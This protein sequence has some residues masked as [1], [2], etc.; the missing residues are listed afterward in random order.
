MAFF[1]LVVIKCA[2]ISA[3]RCLS[4]TTYYSSLT[5]S[6]PSRK[7][8]QNENVLERRRNF[9]SSD[10][11]G[12]KLQSWNSVE[13]N[14]LE[15]RLLLLKKAK[16][17]FRLNFSFRHFSFLFLLLLEN[18]HNFSELNLG[19]KNAAN[20]RNWQSEKVRRLKKLQDANSWKYNRCQD[21][22]EAWIWRQRIAQSTKKSEFWILSSKQNSRQV[23]HILKWM[24][25]CMTW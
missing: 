21:S 3:S 14:L 23:I 17:D 7:L 16:I 6:S 4:T 20:S 19:G 12:K 24:Q 1:F 9:K 11:R 18:E 10:S 13:E 8:Q 22:R 2:Q 5:A 15:V 25:V